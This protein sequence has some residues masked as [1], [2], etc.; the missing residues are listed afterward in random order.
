VSS[1]ANQQQS[2]EA[3]SDPPP[4]RSRVGLIAIAL[5]A[6]AAMLAFSLRHRFASLPDATQHFAVGDSLAP[7]VVEPLFAT[8]ATLDS[9]STTG[10]VVL[11][12]LWGPWCPPCRKELPE[13]VSACNLYLSRDDFVL[14]PVAVAQRDE[15]Y[16]TLAKDV[17][18]FMRYADLNVAVYC[19][20]ER[21]LRQV[22]QQAGIYTGSFP[23]TWL[24]DR[25]GVIRAVWKG[26]H[27]GTVEQMQESVQRVLDGSAS[28]APNQSSNV[29][30]EPTL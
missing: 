11:I 8:D 27:P 7:F 22:A 17:E 16:A 5:L 23:V 29:D 3:A 24:I 30:S 13:I 1:S 9:A 2:H 25:R 14:L 21:R 10:K 6:G 12:N 19:D 26:Y 4:R 28:A 20:P 18:R 15:E